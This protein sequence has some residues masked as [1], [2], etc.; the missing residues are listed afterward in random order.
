MEYYCGG[1]RGI[2]IPTQKV[3]LRKGEGDFQLGIGR[4][5]RPWPVL[6]LDTGFFRYQRELLVIIPL[7]PM[8]WRRL[9]HSARYALRLSILS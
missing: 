8:I 3:R 6:K 5:E 2:P 1:V 9:G 7:W 4:L